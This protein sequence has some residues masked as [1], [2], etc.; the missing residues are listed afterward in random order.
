VTTNTVASPSVTLPPSALASTARHHTAGRSGCVRRS[1]PGFLL[2]APGGFEP[3]DE[4]PYG[5]LDMAGSREEWMRDVVLQSEPPRYRKRGGRWNSYVESVFRVASRAEAS[6][7][8]AVAAQ[9][10]RL[11]LRKP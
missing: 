10:F 1:K 11:V 9:G 6:Q 3:R 8:Y 2:D 7:D 5:V 4:S